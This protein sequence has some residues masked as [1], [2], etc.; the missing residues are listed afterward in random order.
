LH[1]VRIKSVR[2]GASGTAIVAAG[3]SSYTL[4]PSQAEELGLPFSSL[5]PGAELDETEA[6][7]LA[8]A[9]E[10]YEAEKRGLLLLARAEQ[11]A[12]MLRLKLESKGFSKKASNMAIERLDAEHILSDRRFAEAYAASRLSRRAEGPA[13][14]VASLRGRGV[15]G[16]T[17]KAAVAAILGPAE[18][19][20]AI[21][22]AAE[23]EL[24]RSGGDQTAAKARLRALGFKS[25]EIS[26]YFEPE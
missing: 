17:A 24:R 23:K 1:Y 12:Y 6:E 8:L 10:A 11:S 18:R 22:K 19:L 14:L 2:T 20:A 16:D 26:E 3:G 9:A 7:V 13:S 21:A 5:V 25:N 4:R 15:D